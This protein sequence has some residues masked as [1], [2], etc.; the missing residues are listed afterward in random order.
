MCCIERLGVNELTK[1]QL[2]AVLD[3]LLQP[4]VHGFVVEEFGEQIKAVVAGGF[5]V[6]AVE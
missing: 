4:F 6:D 1:Q 2:V 5:P 3:Q